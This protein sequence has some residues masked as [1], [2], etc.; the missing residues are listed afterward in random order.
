MAN[1]MKKPDQLYPLSPTSTPSPMPVYIPDPSLKGESFDQLIKNRGIRFIHRKATP[2]P[3]MRSLQDQS[4]NPL[5]PICNGNGILFYA[6]TEIFGIFYSNSLEKNYEMQGI[7]EV[8]TAVVTLP[9]E[10]TDGKQAEFNTWDQLVIPD[11][12]VRMW[13]M[14][15]YEV[16]A[17][18][19]QSLRYAIHNIDFIAGAVNNQL[20]VFEEGVNY[21]IV[22]GDIQWIPGATP[23]IDPASGRG[24][25]FV[26]QYF[27]NPVYNVLQHMRELRI[28]QQYIG[29]TKVAKRLPQQIL[30]KRDFLSRPAETEASAST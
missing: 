9:T 2:C 26:V 19:K 1:D 21:N 4:H 13:E 25:V 27:A 3:N 18:N 22:D 24:D 28:S 20:V 10:Y 23:S 30:V 16:R 14:K 11:F 8:G 29:G 5:C 7:W 6:E 12:T 15:E 17:D